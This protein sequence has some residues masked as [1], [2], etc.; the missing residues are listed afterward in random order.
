MFYTRSLTSYRFLT[1]ATEEVYLCRSAVQHSCQQSLQALPNC[2]RCLMFPC[3]LLKKSLEGHSGIPHSVR[4]RSETHRSFYTCCN[5]NACPCT[6]I[7]CVYN[8]LPLI[9]HTPLLSL[10]QRS[11][12]SNWRQ[13]CMTRGNFCSPMPFCRKK[14]N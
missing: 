7:V 10:K 13:S 3:H 5:A 2:I 1:F 14:K 12:L 8:T 9:W 4:Y 6:T 11:L